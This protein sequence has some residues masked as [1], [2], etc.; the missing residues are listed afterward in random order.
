MLDWIWSHAHVIA[1]AIVTAIGTFATL[2]QNIRAL[3]DRRTLRAQEQEEHAH[4]GKLLDLL[5]KLDYPQSEQYRAIRIQLDSDI[6]SSYARLRVLAEKE[7]DLERDPNYQLTFWQ[8]LFILFPPAGR[9][10]TWIHALT[11]T[12]IFGLPLVVLLWTSFKPLTPATYADLLVL[13]L[14]GGL[15]FRGWAMAERRWAAG[16]APRPWAAT[17][18]FLSGQPISKWMLAAQVSV[19][20][21]LLCALESLEDI[22]FNVA[23]KN[24]APHPGPTLLFVAFLLGAGIC[25]A[26]VAAERNHRSSLLPDPV[27]RSW[28]AFFLWKKNAPLKVWVGTLVCVGIALSPTLFLL[29]GHRRRADEIFTDGLDPLEL[30]FLWVALLVASNRWLN[31]LLIRDVPTMMHTT[32]TA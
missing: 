5:R 18:I 17:T 23:R 2:R 21:C 7:A 32:V 19:C 10:A 3:T 29:R 15:A 31:S 6:K 12:F 8:R 16:L 11:Y 14:F 25:R 1:S 9:R 13:A 30:F 24:S 22:F 28:Y 26:W 27:R 4:L 20:C